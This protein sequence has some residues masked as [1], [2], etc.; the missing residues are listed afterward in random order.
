MINE[1][2]LIN[3][4]SLPIID[5]HLVND[6]RWSIG[7]LPNHVGCIGWSGHY[8]NWLVDLI[9][10]EYWLVNDE[11]PTTMILL[12]K[13]RLIQQFNGWLMTYNP[14]SANKKGDIV[15]NSD[16]N[17]RRCSKGMK[18]AFCDVIIRFYMENKL[19]NDDTNAVQWWCNMLW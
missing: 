4:L 19:S 11:C 9:P 5:Q 10:V 16:H 18:P 7:D 1:W 14:W 3:H 13:D 15:V 8:S 6:I 17:D 2:Y 12:V